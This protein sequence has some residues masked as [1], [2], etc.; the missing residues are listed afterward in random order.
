MKQC[1]EGFFPCCIFLLSNHGVVESTVERWVSACFGIRSETEGAR[2]RPGLVME[3]IRSS[4]QYTERACVF[5]LY[6]GIK[7]KGESTATVGF[8]AIFEVE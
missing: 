8:K 4:P 7:K 2:G 5:I 1:A 6:V 3:A